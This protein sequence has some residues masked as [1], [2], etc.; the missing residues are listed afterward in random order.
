M[1]LSVFCSDMNFL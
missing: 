1:E